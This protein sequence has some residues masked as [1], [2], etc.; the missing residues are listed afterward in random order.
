MLSLPSLLLSPLPSSWS[1]DP[2]PI[3]SPQRGTERF[4]SLRLPCHSRPA[5][6]GPELALLESRNAAAWMSP[7]G[8][9][10]PGVGQGPLLLCPVL[11]PICLSTQIPTLWDLD[12]GG[13]SPHQPVCLNVHKCFGNSVLAAETLSPEQSVSPNQGAV[14]ESSARGG[15]GH[16]GAGAG[17]KPTDP[18]VSSGTAWKCSFAGDSYFF[19]GR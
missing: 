11:T 12:P 2:P 9:S 6:P 10:S 16:G 17:G 3:T 13:F 5:Y 14:P 8:E 7:P 19:S 4:G 18:K 1:S 15:A